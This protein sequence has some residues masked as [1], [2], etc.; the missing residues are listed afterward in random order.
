MAITEKFLESWGSSSLLRSAFRDLCEAAASERSPSWRL[1]PLAEILVSMLG[2]GATSSFGTVRNITDLLDARTHEVELFSK[3]DEFTPPDQLHQAHWLELAETA[4]TRGTELADVTV[5]LQYRRARINWRLPI[6]PVTFFHSAWAIP[7]ARDSSEDIPEREELL[8]V[9]E[10]SSALGSEDPGEEELLVLARIELGT[11]AISG[12]I[13]AAMEQVDALLNLM[14]SEGGASWEHTGAAAVVVN[15]E[16]RR[17]SSGS[18]YSPR[19]HPHSDR[20]GVSISEEIL[21]DWGA[22]LDPVMRS[23][24]M[25][26]F[27]VEALSTFRDASMTSHRDVTWGGERAVSERIATALEDHV[28]ELVSSLASM[29]PDTVSDQLLQ[30]AI[31]DWFS[32]RVVSAIMS[33]TQRRNE[34]HS[35]DEQHDLANE[36]TKLSRNG[37]RR[38]VLIQEAVRREAD[39]RGFARDPAE[40]LGIAQA[41]RSVRDPA[42]KAKLFSEFEQ[43]MRVLA[44]RHRRVRNAITHGNPVLPGTLAGVRKYSRYIAQQAIGVALESYKAN[45]PVVQLLSKYAASSAT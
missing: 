43:E 6:G 20:Y 42:F 17:T 29:E 34:M 36:I 25:S 12:A 35:F 41:C 22:E 26:P 24:R 16:V 27:L 18:K 23:R 40:E 15:G 8:A 21:E 33:P 1:V 28:L 44:K 4:V 38:V 30:F 10:R 9:I 13:P 45:K 32:E 5:W 19:G 37:N 2:E 39:L 11:R 3:Y 14:V 31:H 7:R